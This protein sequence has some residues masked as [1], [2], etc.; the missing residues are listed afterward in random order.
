[1]EI[2]RYISASGKDIFGDYIKNLKDIKTKAIINTR[3][4]R[5]SV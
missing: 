5:V 2:R 1:M 3:I 4:A